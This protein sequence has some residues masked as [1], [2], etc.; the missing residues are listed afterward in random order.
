MKKLY[1]IRHA[2]SS[3][4]DMTLDDFE[5]PLNKRG[6]K[7]APEMGRRLR[8]KKIKPDLILSSPALRAKTTAKIIAKKVKYFESIEYKQK[9]YD[10][11]ASTLHALLHKIDD[12]HDIVFLLGHNPWLNLLAEKYVGLDENIPTC[13]IVEIEFHCASWVYISKENAT[14]VSFDYPKKGSNG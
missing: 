5:R 2:K 10:A 12:A 4:E 14:L 7:N 1:L 9:I 11:N 3:W 13:G 6:E 8:G